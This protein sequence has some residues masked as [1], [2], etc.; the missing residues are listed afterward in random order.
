MNREIL[1]RGK[2]TD[3]GK[4]FT[5]F[6]R[7]NSFYKNA[8]IESPGNNDFYNVIPETV[9][10]YTGLLDKNGVKIFEGDILE[11]RC[12]GHKQCTP[13]VVDMKELYMSMGATDGY[14]A[15]YEDDLLQVIGNIHGNP[16]LLEAGNESV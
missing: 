8:I 9:G 13:M 12:G 16:E 3:N 7:V 14:R 2:R 4:W 11:Y 5:G 6:F 15:I 10:E 1:F